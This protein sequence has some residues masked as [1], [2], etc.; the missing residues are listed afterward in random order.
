MTKEELAELFLARLN[1][2]AEAAPH[3]NFLFFVNDFVPMFGITDRQ[4]LQE[5]VNFLGDEGLI[6]QRS[7]GYSGR[8]QRRHHDG[9]EHL[10]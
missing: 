4:E 6:D 5:A 1:E 10:R 2:L 3:P 8:H 9:R 7:D